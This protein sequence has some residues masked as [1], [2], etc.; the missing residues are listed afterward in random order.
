M[1]PEM[2]SLNLLCERVARLEV[3]LDGHFKMHETVLI[4]LLL[5]ILVGVFISMVNHFTLRRMIRNGKGE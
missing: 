4:V 1:S 2:I 5:P 3:M